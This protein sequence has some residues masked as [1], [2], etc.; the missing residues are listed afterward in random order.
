M[1]VLLSAMIGESGST[2]FEYRNYHSL[3]HWLLDAHAGSIGGCSKLQIRE[4]Y[5]QLIC[6]SFLPQNKP[7]IMVSKVIKIVI[8]DTFVAMAINVFTFL[9]L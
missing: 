8:C 9:L 1:Q 2:C 7:A 4:S 6:E 5:I 3:V